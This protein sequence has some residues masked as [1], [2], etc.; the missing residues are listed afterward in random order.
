MRKCGKVIVYA[1]S[2]SPCPVFSLIF[3]HNND[4]FFSAD[5][6]YIK[7][8]S[9]SMVELTNNK[10]RGAKTVNTNGNRQLQHNSGRY[11]QTKFELKR[12]SENFAHHLPQKPC[13]PNNDFDLSVINQSI[14]QSFYFRH[15]PIPTHIKEKTRNTKIQ[16]LKD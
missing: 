10:K 5:M 16:K 8:H 7:V 6:Q 3:L 1:P 4:G 9:P 14:N 13:L 12:T 11:N 15:Q 2:I